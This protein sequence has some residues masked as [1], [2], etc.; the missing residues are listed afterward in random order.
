MSVVTIR[1]AADRVTQNLDRRLRQILIVVRRKGLAEVLQFPRFVPPSLDIRPRLDASEDTQFLEAR[2]RTR[3]SAQ[4]NG[5]V[6]AGVVRQDALEMCMHDVIHRTV[7]DLV[8]LHPAVE[9]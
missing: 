8:R 9:Q 1:N 3:S 2:V 6:R 4:E 7:E 5:A